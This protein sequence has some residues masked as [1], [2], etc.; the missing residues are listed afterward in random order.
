MWRFVSGYL[1]IGIYSCVYYERD[2]IDFK[3]SRS[4]EKVYIY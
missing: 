4:E 3:T 1:E 2:R